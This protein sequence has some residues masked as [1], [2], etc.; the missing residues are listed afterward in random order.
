M[1]FGS[2]RFDDVIRAKNVVVFYLFVCHARVRILFSNRFGRSWVQNTK[3]A[4]TFWTLFHFFLNFD[5]K[6]ENLKKK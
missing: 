4:D 3:F 2:I 5:W 6:R 1:K